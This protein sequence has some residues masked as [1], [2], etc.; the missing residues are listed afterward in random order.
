MQVITNKYRY[1]AHHAQYCHVHT[2][3]LVHT[4]IKHSQDWCGWLLIS[5][6]QESS[7]Q[8]P[9]R[10]IN[11]CSPLLKMI[12]QLPSVRKTVVFRTRPS[13]GI[14]IRRLIP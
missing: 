5:G 3:A 9:L 4:S 2:L 7:A 1:A 8:Q 6:Y 12:G 10:P 14:C 11:W 13:K